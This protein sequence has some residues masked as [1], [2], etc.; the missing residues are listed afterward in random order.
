[1][2]KW[3]AGIGFV[4]LGTLIWCYVAVALQWQGTPNLIE[5]L[6][7]VFSWQVLASGAAIG[8]A[9]KYG[10]EISAWLTRH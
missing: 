1:M 3:L 4:M 7:V 9:G 5:L 2:N 6:K 10:G 8:V